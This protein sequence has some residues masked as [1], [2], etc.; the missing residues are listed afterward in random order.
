MRQFRIVEKKS[1]TSSIS[2][3]YVQ[4]RK[5]FLFWTYWDTDTEPNYDPK[6]YANLDVAEQSILRRKNV[7]PETVSVKY[8]NV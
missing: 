5:R 4:E 3:F 6:V 7:K 1:P 2:L 8:Y